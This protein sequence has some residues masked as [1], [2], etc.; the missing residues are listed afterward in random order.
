VQVFSSAINNALQLLGKDAYC[1]GH[2]D[3]SILQVNR[4]HRIEWFKDDIP[5]NGNTNKTVLR[6]NQSG[7]YYAVSN[8]FIRLLIGH[9]KKA[10]DDR[11]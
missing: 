5:L 1:F 6:I 2:G 4:E 3:S 11:L 7:T 8:G 10:C 9:N